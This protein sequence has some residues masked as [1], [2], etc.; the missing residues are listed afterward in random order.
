MVHGSNSNFAILVKTITGRSFEYPTGGVFLIRTWWSYPAFR[1]DCYCIANGTMA[2]KRRQNFSKSELEDLT[3]KAER[4][5]EKVIFFKLNSSVTKHAKDCLWQVLADRMYVVREGV[6]RT[7]EEVRKKS[8]VASNLKEE[9]SP[10]KKGVQKDRRRASCW[11][12]YRTPIDEKLAVV[13]GETDIAGN[14]PFRSAITSDIDRNFSYY[15]L[16]N[17][18][19]SVLR[20]Y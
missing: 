1:N 5:K 12:S 6:C 20:F 15:F 19:I 18:R 8:N 2:L 14:W 4:Y 16:I 3:V 9:R 7:A 13:V 10:T 17:M 11:G